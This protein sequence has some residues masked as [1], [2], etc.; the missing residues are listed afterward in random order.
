MSPNGPLR[1]LVA[2]VLEERG[3]SI[4]SLF[5]NNI[6]PANSPVFNAVC[7]GDLQGLKIMLAA[8]KASIRD[9]DEYGASL[10]QVS[11]MVV[12]CS[13]F[14]YSYSNRPQYAFAYGHPELCKFFLDAGA[15][16]DHC[17]SMAGI[18]SI[19]DEYDVN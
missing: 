14:L 11:L 16:P 6:R 8:G 15:D 3:A 7:Q 17:A 9:H 19:Y 5:V 18:R 4:S 13:S 10:L 2:S 1:M 12:K